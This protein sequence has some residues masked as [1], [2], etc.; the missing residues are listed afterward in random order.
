MDL[1]LKQDISRGQTEAE[2]NNEDKRENCVEGG[3]Q[4]GLDRHTFNCEGYTVELV[5]SDTGY[6]AEEAFM[7]YIKMMTA[8]DC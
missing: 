5:F 1:N 8:L 3:K 6:T 2:G 7:E 4:D